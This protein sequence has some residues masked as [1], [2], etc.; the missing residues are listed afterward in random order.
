MIKEKASGL[1]ICYKLLEKK[2]HPPGWLA[3][4]VGGLLFILPVD[5]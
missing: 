1:N 4:G 3:A 2:K 5:F